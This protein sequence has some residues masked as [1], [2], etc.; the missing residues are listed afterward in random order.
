M[1]LSQVDKVKKYL[2]VEKNHIYAKTDLKITIDTSEM[3]VDEEE[4]VDVSNEESGEELQGSVSIPGM[5]NIEVPV[6]NDEIQLYFKFKINLIIPD[7]VE[8]DKDVYYYYYTD[9]DLITFAETKSNATDI[10]ILDSLFENRVKYLRGDLPKQV[11]A[12]YE[13]LVNTKNIQLQHIETIL[14]I[15]YGEYTDNGFEPVRL[16][17]GQKYSKSNALSTKES[18]HRLNAATGFNYGYTKDNISDNITRKYKTKKTDLE[19][20][21]FGKYDELGDN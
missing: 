15:M 14:T 17:P 20:V 3:K 1:A 8:R 5:L 21:I 9:G 4:L 16:T 13:Q 2:R 12:I 10:M 19:K 11:L 7:N 6:F 18:A